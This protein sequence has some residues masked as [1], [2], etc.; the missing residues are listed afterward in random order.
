MHMVPFILNRTLDHP[1][2]FGLLLSI[3]TV[4]GQ[5]YVAYNKQVIIHMV[6]T[7]SLLK[8]IWSFSCS[9][10][11]RTIWTPY[12]I[13][14]GIKQNG[15]LLVKCKVISVVSGYVVHSF[16]LRK[17]LIPTLNNIKLYTDTKVKLRKHYHNQFSF[18]VRKKMRKNWIYINI[19][20]TLLS[21]SI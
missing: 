4:T 17:R 20:N 14:D 9:F 5:K 18:T 19:L 10:C 1:I 8:E 3:Y 21:A 16:V 12:V 11:Y 13:N 6:R 7:K 2:T 15:G